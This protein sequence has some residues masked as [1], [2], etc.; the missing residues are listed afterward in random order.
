M[1]S[2]GGREALR[3]ARYRQRLGKEKSA[4]ITTGKAIEASGISCS[5]TLDKEIAS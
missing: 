5:S 3:I 4:Q 1:S 2:K